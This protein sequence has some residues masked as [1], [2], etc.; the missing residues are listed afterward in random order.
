MSIQE[1]SLSSLIEWAVMPTT[2]T[3]FGL[4]GTNVVS[5][6]VGGTDGTFAGVNGVLVPGV[7]P[8]VSAYAVLVIFSPFAAAF[9]TL[10]VKVN[11]PVEPAAS[12]PALKVKT[13][14]ASLRPLDT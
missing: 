8:S 13:S 10:T 3:L 12:F 2:V 6:V 9:L 11:L 1:T 4:D 14:F 7:K 5:V